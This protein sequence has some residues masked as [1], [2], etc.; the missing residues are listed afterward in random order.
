[1]NRLLL[2]AALCLLIT[3]QVQAQ[4]KLS[5][6]TFGQIEARS[7]GPA[8]MGG[9]ITAI[10]GV[11]SNP[12]ILY[13]GSAGGG[14]WKTTTAGF[15]FEPVFEKYPQSIG[16][17][18]IDQNHPDTLW[19]GT[20]ECNMRNSV[21]V[22]LGIY[23]ST[24]GGRNWTKKGLDN[25]EH[26]SKII[27]HPNDANTVFVA[28]PGKLWSDSPDRGLYK[29]TDGGKTWEKILYTDEKTGCAD[30]I[31][32]PRNPDVLL[33]SMWQFRRTPYSFASGGPGSALYKS[34]DGGKNW[35]KITDGLPTGEFGRIALALAPSAPDNVLAIVE[36][37]KTSLLISADGG[38]SW[39]YQSA[40]SNVTAR[41]FY[42]STLVVDPEDPKRVYRP[43]FSL[44]ISRDGGYS[45]SDASDAGGWVHSDHHALWINP[46]STNHLYLGTDGGVYMS[47]DYGV[48]W[49]HLNTLPVSQFY[50]VQVDQKTPYNVYGGLQD[51][52][53]WRG[54]SQSPGGIEN[55]DW[56]N[57]GGGDGF[58]VQPDDLDPS[59]VYSESQGGNISRVNTRTN[60]SRF[61]QPQQQKGDPD[62]RWNWNAP[63]VKS[64]ANPRVLYCG[65]QFLFKTE[66][67]GH[68]WKRIS[69]DL[70]TNDSLKLKQYSSGGLTLDNTS[71]E[72]HCTIFSIGPSP[73]DENLIYA[74][75]DDGNI[76]V[77]RDGGRNWELVSSNIPGV[78]AG[79]W[80]SRV[81]PSRHALHTVYATFDNHGYGDMRTYAAKSTDGGKTWSLISNS[82]TLQ[83]FA[84]VIIED[85]VNP[86]MLFLGTEFGLYFSND[87]GQNWVLYKS[88]FPEYVAVHDLVI[89]P[90]TNDL[91]VG[92]HGRG[93]FIIDDISPLRRMT[94]ELLER[95]VALLPTRPTAVTTG[96]YGQ[97]FPN[98]DSY[99]GPN[100]PESAVIQY[101]LKD[102]L[103]TGDVTI[104]VYDPSGKLL[105]SMPGT[106]RKGINMVRWEMRVT[107]PKAAKGVLV[108][109]E[110]GVYAGFVGQ[111]ALPGTYAI[112]LK[113]GDFTDE[114]RLVLVPD[115]LQPELDYSARR[116]VSDK[117]FRM[118]ESLGLLVAQVQSL[119]DNADQRA[120]ESKDK[121]LK[122]S[123]LQYSSNLESFRKTLTETIE[124]SGITGEKQLRARIGRLYLF[125][126]ISDELPT[127]S[128]LDAMVA[129]QE[130]LQN[131][132]SKADT[133]FG[134]D[135]NTLNNGLKKEKLAPLVVIDRVQF[136]KDYGKVSAPGT[137]KGQDW[138]QMM[139]SFDG[140]RD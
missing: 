68:S 92:T 49:T 43:A 17:L 122:N 22:G 46:N 80:V 78:P 129:L 41:P 62:L 118:V 74:G 69:P 11:N 75:T 126:E 114:G 132:Q 110:P 111:M 53:S 120:K 6:S 124:S 31:M 51:N 99:A 105:V 65:A 109:G 38:E 16:A 27:I 2:F 45:F 50:H 117:L 28:V 104:E 115:P 29:T 34:T 119:K 5:S 23:R 66:D 79:T 86:D 55:K 26:I 8:V 59:I 113:A 18:A 35:R 24:D 39:K 130:E 20:G 94:P 83:G 70:T 33:A 19:V 67:R 112:K 134:K 37:E 85:V 30:I 95:D 90:A 21:S 25:S 89:Q 42:F 138:R 125:T 52:G 60:Q 10:E 64:P 136:E 58:W 61:I 36:S 71:A 47:L 100:A 15:S 121:R 57:V 103:N 137:G 107:P 127:Q 84:R 73:L 123:L 81:E 48:T 88:R 14:V 9:R 108:Q 12:K 76:Q 1:M 3:V 101:Y 106:K 116:D 56:E 44:S 131:A 102:R 97:A 140:T 82:N 32:D 128:I 93:I 63:I 87:G 91:V 13:V 4:T 40:S 133:F 139:E 72:N 54:P 98:T 135:L 77:T 7:I 96:H